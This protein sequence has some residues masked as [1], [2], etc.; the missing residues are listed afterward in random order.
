MVRD[1]SSNLLSAGRCGGEIEEE[2]VDLKATGEGSIETNR[3]I[4]RE[5]VLFGS[6]RNDELI[7]TLS[8]SCLFMTIGP[9]LILLNKAIYTDFRFP[10]PIFVS[11]LGIFASAVTAYVSIGAGAASYYSTGSEKTAVPP[12][13][14]QRPQ[15]QRQHAPYYAYQVIPIAACLAASLAFGNTPCSYLF[16]SYYFSICLPACLPACLTLHACIVGLHF[17][18]L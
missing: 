13:D 1:A 7:H 12:C 8:A 3:T 16:L 18:H 6:R 5:G 14:Q 2:T 4:G 17:F 9:T 10:F 11:F 15:Q